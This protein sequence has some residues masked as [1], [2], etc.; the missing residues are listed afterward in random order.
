MDMSFKLKSMV[1]IKK[2]YNSEVYV[3]WSTSNE[4]KI[5]YYERLEKII[6]LQDH[7]K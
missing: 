6:E 5:D 1:K 3:K 4:F 2:T 7:N